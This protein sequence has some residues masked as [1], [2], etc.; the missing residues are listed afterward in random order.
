VN[1]SV[2]GGPNAGAHATKSTSVSGT[3]SF[4]YTGNGGIGTDTI[5]AIATKGSL[6]ATSTATKVWIS[7]GPSLMLLSPNGGEALATGDVFPIQW[8][9]PTAAMH[10]NLQYSID[11]GL[12]WKTITNGVTGT[13]FD[14]IVPAQTSNKPKSKVRVV[15]FDASNKKIGT[16]ASDAPF[17]VEVVNVISPNGG[18]TLTSGSMQ[19]IS[20]DSHATVRPVASLKLLFTQNGGVSYK[21]VTA[22]LTGNPGTFGWTIPAV[23]AAKTK[24]KVKVVLKDMTGLSVGSDLSDSF[25]TIAP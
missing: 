10:V 6:S 12:T 13:S 14:W 23:T 22:S 4:T 7:A 2:V 9:A 16:D 19:T 11:N 18:E 15:A 20:W 25:F 17:T 5:Q 21:A 8:T 1:L 24:C 3:V